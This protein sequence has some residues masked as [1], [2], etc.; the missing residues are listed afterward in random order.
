MEKK[1]GNTCTAKDPQAP[2]DPTE[3]ANANPGE[4]STTQTRSSSRQT[5]SLGT[6]TIAPTEDVPPDETH[7]IS[8]ELKDHEGNA[9]PNE[10][11]RVKLPDGSIVSGYTDAEGKAK[12]EG[13]PDGG[14]AEINF[15][16]ISGD[17]WE[18]A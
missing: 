7:W 13:L 1:S 10:Q 4:V 12:V 2:K 14:E 18:P 17:E 5:V 8:I 11:Y 6:S 3:A 16:R 9:M 15:P